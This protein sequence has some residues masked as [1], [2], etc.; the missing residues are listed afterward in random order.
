MYSFS[1]NC[2]ASVPISTFMCLWA[3]YIFP[4]SVHI[5]SCNRIDRPIVGTYKSLT[6]TWIW[7]IGTE[8][9]QFLLWEYLLWISVLCL[10]S[11]IKRSFVFIYTSFS[12]SK[13]PIERTIRI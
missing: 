7:E 8:A 4:G 11:A 6:D 12:C 2:A 3:I 9:A 13:L 10:C 1:G 5:F